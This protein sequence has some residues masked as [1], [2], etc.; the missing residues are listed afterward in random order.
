MQDNTWV[1]SDLMIVQHHIDQLQL[2]PYELPHRTT[3]DDTICTTVHILSPEKTTETSCRKNVKKMK[4]H[5]AIETPKR[6]QG[7]T[8]QCFTDYHSYIFGHSVSNP[9]TSHSPTCHTLS[10]P[11]QH[12]TTHNVVPTQTAVNQPR[13]RFAGKTARRP[14]KRIHTYTPPTAFSIKETMAEHQE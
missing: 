13:K 7:T 10:T 14:R 4:G 6:K 9:N 12:S 1:R 2:P 8:L 11:F 5:V 3:S